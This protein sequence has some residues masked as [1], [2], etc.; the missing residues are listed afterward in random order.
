MK[1]VRA[2]LLVVLGVSGVLP[3][4]VN[5]QDDVA[6]R[7]GSLLSV[8]TEEYQKAVDKDGRLLSAAEYDETVGFFADLRTASVRFTGTNAGAVRATIDTL[9]RAVHAKLPSVEIDALRDHIA[10]LLGT[11]GMVELPSAPLDL[12]H[13]QQLFAARCASCHGDRGLGNGTA[14]VALVASGEV[15]PPAIGDPHALP[16]LDPSLVYSVVTVG[17]RG[18]AMPAFSE[19]LTPQQ[20]WDVINYVYHLRGEPLTLPTRVGRTEA[21]AAAVAAFATMGTRWA[22]FW[23]SFLIILREGFEAILVIGAVVALLLKLGHRRHLRSMWVGVVVGVLASALTAVAIRTIFAELPASQEMIEAISLLLAVVVLFWVSYWLISKVEAARWQRFIHGQVSRAL[24]R[25]GGK[26]LAMVAFLAVYREG[27]ETALFYQALLSQGAVGLP[28]GLGI[29]VGGIALAV[30]FVLFYRFGVKIPMRPF[31]AVTSVFLYLMA[32][33]FAGHGMR[34]LQESGVLPETVLS[35][36]PH[37]DILG[38]FPTVQTLMAQGV[39]L[40]LFIFALLKSL[41][42]APVA[43]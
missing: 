25:G 30:I 36:A 20:R 39:L 34:E 38:I 28:L 12:A 7:I 41:R 29:V 17:I 18:T 10:R 6:R 35:F 32:F 3:L 14:A 16:A 2:L 42:P 27:A 26:A 11:A 33:V 9:E 31:F 23:Q 8:A 5:A 40:A 4:R 37:V 21:D 22:T 1:M 13:G 24:D 19:T 43:G 15:A